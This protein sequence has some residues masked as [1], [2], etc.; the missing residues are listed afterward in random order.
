VVVRE[1]SDL[2]LFGYG[3][4]LLAQAWEAADMLAAE[5]ISVRLVNMPWLNRVDRSWL[6]EVIGSAADV[7][8]LDNHYIHGGQGA[9]LAAAAAEAGLAEETRFTRIGLSELPKCGT[10]EEVLRYHA[11]DARGI[12]NRVLAATGVKDVVA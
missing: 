5:G 2:V 12:F 4:W 3:S 7:V 10:N 1:G 11:L 9:M 8:L 6:G